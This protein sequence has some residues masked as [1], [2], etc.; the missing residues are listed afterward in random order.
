MR[1]IRDTTV[2]IHPTVKLSFAYALDRVAEK[3]NLNV[4]KA[5]EKCMEECKEF[6][7]LIKEFHN[8]KRD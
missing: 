8:I 2:T 5:L 6:Q 1:E 3:S 7:E 4:G